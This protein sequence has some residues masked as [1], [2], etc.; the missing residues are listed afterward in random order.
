M[1]AA[2]VVAV[3]R[4]RTVALMNSPR[5]CVCVC[6]CVCE[7]ECEQE[8]LQKTLQ[9]CAMNPLKRMKNQVPKK[10]AQPLSPAA[11]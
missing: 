8:V 5:L 4:F 7:K 11:Q 1:R 10:E 6:L 9:T 3:D 2:M